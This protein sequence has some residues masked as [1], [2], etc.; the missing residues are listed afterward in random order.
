[1]PGPQ[2]TTGPPT[3]SCQEGV[4]PLKPTFSHME[5][6]ASGL[7][8]EGSQWRPGLVWPVLDCQVLPQV[9]SW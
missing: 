5:M 6:W 4:L 9:P 3:C 8:K 1:M 2:V 7:P